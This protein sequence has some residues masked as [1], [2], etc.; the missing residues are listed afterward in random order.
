MA[1]TKGKTHSETE[2]I[3]GYIRELEK[4]VTSLRKQIRQY[5]KYDRTQG[6]SDDE[7][8]DT[9]DTVVE[10]KRTK[11]CGYCGKGK[12]VETLDLGKRGVFGECSTCG[13][14]GKIR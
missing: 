12:L 10:L 7:R 4:E 13:E 14:K 6:S 1:K 9:E 2:H 3:R 8:T 11:D 5:E